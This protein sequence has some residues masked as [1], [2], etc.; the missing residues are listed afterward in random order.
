MTPPRRIPQVGEL[1][2][3]PSGNVVEL[4]RL[5][6]ASLLTWNCVYIGVAW[7]ERICKDPKRREVPLRDDWLSRCGRL[8]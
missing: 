3:L 7:G 8:V 5:L 6:P 4:K 1:L 2:L